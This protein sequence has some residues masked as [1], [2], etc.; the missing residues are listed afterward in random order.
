MFEPSEYNIIDLTLPYNKGMAGYEFETA[1]TVEKEGWNARILHLYSHSGTHMD[2]PLHFNVTEQTIV[3]YP[4]ATFVGKAWV[5]P[6]EINQPNQLLAVPDLGSIASKFNPG[7]SLL[8]Q[9]QWSQY[10]GEL[11]Y[12]DHLPRI[13]PELAD[14]C[15]QHKVN[16]LGVEAPSV[17][18][19]NNLGEVTE[20]HRTL[21]GGGVVIIE[22]LTNLTAIKKEQ[23]ILTA[24]PLKI[25]GGDGAPAR[26][27]VFEK[28]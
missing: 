21:L 17:A 20:I 6:I 14:W 18:D 8:L 4:V 9:T 10:I 13:S 3:D 16:M 1:K 19:V 15:V 28:K 27:I 2:A 24:L 7:E 22:G 26:V 23:V 5:V 12:R 25:E 11:K